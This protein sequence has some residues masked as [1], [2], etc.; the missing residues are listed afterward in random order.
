[1]DKKNK[2]MLNSILVWI[3][4]LGMLFLVGYAF[5]LDARDYPRQHPDDYCIEGSPSC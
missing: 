2:E 5:Y 1:M 3:V 4:M